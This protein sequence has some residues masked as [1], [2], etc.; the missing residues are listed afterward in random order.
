MA[1]PVTNSGH[2]VKDM[3]DVLDEVEEDL[4]QRLAQ[5]YKLDQFLAAVW[6]LRILHFPK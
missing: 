1:C 6:D 5:D 2:P 4:H 3:E